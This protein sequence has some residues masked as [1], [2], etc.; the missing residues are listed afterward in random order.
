MMITAMS[1]IV[2]KTSSQLSMSPANYAPDTILAAL[3]L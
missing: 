3:A 1:F 2:F